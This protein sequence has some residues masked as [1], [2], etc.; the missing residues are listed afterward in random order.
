MKKSFLVVGLGRL[1]IVIIEE[2]SKHNNV[3]IMAIDSN[4][5]AV[6]KASEIIEHCLICD[7]TSEA[8]LNQISF[9]GISQAIVTIGGNI[10]ATILTTILLKERGVKK[11]SVRIDDDHY[12]KI[13][14]KIGADEVI[15]PERIAG[16]R[17]ANSIIR[18]NITDYF[19]VSDGYGIV[20]ILITDKF[21]PQTL[22]E[23]DSR[24]KY[25]VNI[26]SIKRNKKVFIPKGSD[27]INPGDEVL[28][29]GKDA[30]VAK[31]NSS[32]NGK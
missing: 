11:I 8:A 31:F 1:G 7:S 22:I 32:I 18:D 21:K 2:L 20:Q 16:I 27:T 6:I 4:E 28:V 10:Q 23:L 30:K 26:I 3:E 13:M 19:N 12:E 5:D 25:D 9:D 29:I 24:N 17:Y 14:Y 15:F